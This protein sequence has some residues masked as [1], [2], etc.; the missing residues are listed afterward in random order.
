MIGLCGVGGDDDENAA[1]DKEVV[2]NGPPRICW[3]V[4]PCLDLS[5]DG[6][7]EGDH[8]CQLESSISFT[9]LWV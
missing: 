2:D 5:N 4:V 6:R 7:D 3:E 8:P 9:I 1:N